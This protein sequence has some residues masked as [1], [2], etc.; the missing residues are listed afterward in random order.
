MQHNE[1]IW[2]KMCGNEVENLLQEKLICLYCAALL[3]LKSDCT[4]VT[5][6]KT[7]FLIR[8]LFVFFLRASIPVL[9]YRHNGL[10]E[11]WF[12]T[13]SVRRK[14]KQKQKERKIERMEER[15]EEWMNERRS[16]EVFIRLA[17]I[18]KWTTWSVDKRG[19]N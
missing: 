9:I 1:K 5:Q 10:Y 18:E 16:L 3:T 2:T 14:N 6:R 15:K 13:M 7:S 19:K 4:V 17:T 11:K 12:E 8:C